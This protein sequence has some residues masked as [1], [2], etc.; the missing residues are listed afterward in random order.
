M[1]S[2]RE[3]LLIAN[4]IFRDLGITHCFTG[5]VAASYW[6]IQR[7]TTDIDVIW[8]QEKVEELCERLKKAGF[9]CEI[10]DFSAQTKKSLNLVVL[11]TKSPFHLDLLPPQKEE[12]ERK[13]LVKIFGEDIWIIAPE[14]LI[15]MKI[16]FGRPKDKQ[17]IREMLRKLEDTLD[18]PFLRTEL[19]RLGL[20]HL[21]DEIINNP[22][23]K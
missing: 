3:V 12:L 21:F 13:H 18:L 4:K 19:G 8:T 6:G 17:D 22:S 16:I 23:G 14:D 11:D 5:A 1:R 10:D 20:T 2:F 15:L 7:S 9:L